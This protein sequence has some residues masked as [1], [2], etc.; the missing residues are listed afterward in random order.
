[1]S[2]ANFAYGGMAPITMQAKNGV[3]AIMGKKFANP[4]TLEAVMSAMEKDFPLPFGVPGGMATYRNSLALGFFY[5]FYHDVLS[6]LGPAAGILDKEAVDEIEREI[7]VGNKDH[8]TRFHI[9]RRFWAK[10]ILTLLPSNNAL[11]RPQYTDDI[12]IQN[13]ELIGCLVL[14]TKAHAKLLNVDASPA[15]DVPGVVAWVDRHDVVNPKANQWVRL[16]VM[17]CSLRR[18]RSLPLV[19]PSV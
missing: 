6:T 7:S 10:L 19:N 8:D 14:S 18:K 15:L 11:E 13:N 17:K 1:V 2:E 12:P 16:F 9:R 5:R 4:K 3:A